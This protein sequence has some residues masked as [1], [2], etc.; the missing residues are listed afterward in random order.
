MFV[1]GAVAVALEY[2]EQ[3]DKSVTIGGLVGLSIR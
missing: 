1:S 3:K 2:F